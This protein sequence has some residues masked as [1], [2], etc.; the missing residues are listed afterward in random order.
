MKRVCGLYVHKDTVFC[1]AFNG[2][3]YGPVVDYST[4]TSSIK[5]MG[6]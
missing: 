1:A 2:K 4:L 6:N 5:A 3:K